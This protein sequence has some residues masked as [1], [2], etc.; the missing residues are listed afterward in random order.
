MLG[1]E[2]VDQTHWINDSPIYKPRLKLCFPLSSTFHQVKGTRFVHATAKLQ[3]RLKL[4]L[5]Q[6]RVLHH[7]VYLGGKPSSKKK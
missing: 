7:F 2:L 4:G 1:L 6:T 3:P 5:A